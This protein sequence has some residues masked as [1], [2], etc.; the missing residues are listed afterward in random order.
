MK[1]AAKA[2]DQF[3]AWAIVE[4]MGHRRLAGLAQEVQIAGAGM[5]RLDV[6]SKPPVTQ[7]Y[8]PSSIYCLT[9][10]TEALARAFA[11]RNSPAPVHAYELPLAKDEG[12]ARDGERDESEDMPL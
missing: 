5:I 8:S 12:R 7:F 2:G 1:K 4:L 6:P 9:P 10:T 3:K 11:T